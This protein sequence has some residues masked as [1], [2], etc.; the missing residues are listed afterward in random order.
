LLAEGATKRVERTLGRRRRSKKP[1]SGQRLSGLR[2]Q[3]M[4][5]QHQRAA[6]RRYEAPPLHPALVKQSR[7]EN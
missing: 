4:P 7:A 3:R 1:D 5:P 6:E 2:E